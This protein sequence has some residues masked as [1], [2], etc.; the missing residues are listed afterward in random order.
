MNHEFYMKRC[1]ELAR[2]GLGRVSPNPM[3]GAVLVK[4]DRIIGEGFH[5]KHGG[6]HAEVNCFNS[7]SFSELSYKNFF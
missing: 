1:F 2:L 3:V 5:E 7:G 4:N 6:P